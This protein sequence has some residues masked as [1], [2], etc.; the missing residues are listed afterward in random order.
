MKR[1]IITLL[2]CLTGLLSQYAVA[3]MPDIAPPQV[4]TPQQRERPLPPPAQWVISSDLF[5]WGVNLSG[6]S[7]INAYKTAPTKENQKFLRQMS[8]TGMAWF[9]GSKGP[10]SA[11]LHIFYGELKYTQG[12]NSSNEL[13]RNSFSMGTA[14]L[15][16]RAYKY[17]I[18]TEGNIISSSFSID[19]YVGTRLLA[20][21]A[22]IDS[23]NVNLTNRDEWWM[24]PLIGS[25]FI[26]QFKTNWDIFGSADYAFWNPDNQTYNTM[27]MLQY[28]KLFG[29]S[30]LSFNLGY[31]YM[32]M[33]RKINGVRFEWDMN[34]YGPLFGM[35][36]TI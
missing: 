9:S 5:L 1:K 27:I 22:H 36:L 12:D 20:D 32:Y 16:Y 2:T 15:S 18:S 21:N 30:V 14:G 24:Q 29:V 17:I 8:S 11:F 28:N 33:Y 35:S 19:P 3:G 34:L 26:I 13:T 10:Y 6:H 4:T 31:R 7:F 25:R 23:N